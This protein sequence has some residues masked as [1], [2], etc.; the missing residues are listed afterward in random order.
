[1]PKHQDPKE[2]RLRTLPSTTREQKVLLFNLRELAY[3]HRVASTRAAMT[4]DGML[5]N[6]TPYARNVRVLRHTL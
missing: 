4:Y 1:M 2:E 3:S 6:D 5:G